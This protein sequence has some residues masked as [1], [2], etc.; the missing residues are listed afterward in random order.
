MDRNESGE[1][2]DP[3]SSLQQ[4]QISQSSDAS[5]VFRF[6]GST[7]IFGA[8]PFALPTSSST[9]L[10]RCTKFL[11][12]ICLRILLFLIDIRRS[13][14]KIL[15]KC[16][17]PVHMQKSSGK[18]RLIFYLSYL[19]RFVHFGS[20]PFGTKIIALCFICSSRASHLCFQIWISSRR[21]SFQIIARIWVF[22]GVLV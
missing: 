6:P 8:I 15:L 7:L 22:L 16:I 21:K 1:T 5:D 13:S 14:L 17:T 9:V 3:I 2:T 20:N 18:C 4:D 10:L 12:L 19:N 11:S